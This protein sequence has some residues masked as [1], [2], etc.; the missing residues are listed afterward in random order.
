MKTILGGLKHGIAHAVAAAVAVQRGIHR[1][2]GGA[3]GGL[4]GFLYIEKSSADIRGHAV[5][6]VTQKPLELGIPVEAV[7]A[8]GV[9]DQGEELLTA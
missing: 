2:E 6:A 1:M 9:A 5:V 8:G 4:A 3:P 7:A